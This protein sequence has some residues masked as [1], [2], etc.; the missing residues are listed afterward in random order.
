MESE[1]LKGKIVRKIDENI[2]EVVGW[3]IALSERSFKKKLTVGIILICII[4]A[5]LPF[6]FH[7]IE[8]RDG[9]IINDYILNH[10]PARNVSIP[11]FTL[12]WTMVILFIVRSTKDPY[13][14]LT[15][16]YSFVLLCLCRMISISVVALNPPEGLIALVDPISNSFY[17]KS[18][19]TKDL[20]F[21][22]HTAS[23]WLFF[24]CF[25]RKVEKTAAL[26]CTIAVGFFVLVQHVHYLIDVLAAP[27]FGTI[28]YWVAKKIVNSAP[29]EIPTTS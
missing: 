2:E 24:L 13:L 5:S 21:S 12:I 15:Y 10:L 17:G 29:N 18:F 8:K 7:Y 14:F 11:I 4:L 27:I 28:C 25:R 20:F 19:I 23:Q 1:K 3:K 26:I 6:F 9:Y 22:G 16:L